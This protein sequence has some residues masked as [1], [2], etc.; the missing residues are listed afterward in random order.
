MRH[1]FYTLLAVFLVLALGV[2]S[3]QAEGTV[4]EPEL[5]LEED[6][7]WRFH[8]EPLGFKFGNMLDS[9]QQSTLD[10]R[11]VL[12]GFI[13]IHDTASITAEG[14]PIADKAHCPTGPCI[15]SDNRCFWIQG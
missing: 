1:K 9:H 3:A 5:L 8:A 7:P 11:G 13:Y 15:M 14:Y 12:H 6:Y 4:I 2:S 10:S